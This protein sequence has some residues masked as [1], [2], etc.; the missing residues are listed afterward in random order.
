MPPRRAATKRLTREKGLGAGVQLERASLPS[1]PVESTSCSSK[2][3]SPWG[4]VLHPVQSANEIKEEHRLRACGISLDPSYGCPNNY[5]KKQEEDFV[6]VN[7][8]R[9]RQ[10]VENDADSSE[11][12]VIIVSSDDEPNPN[13]LTKCACSKK[14]CKTNPRCLNY[15]GQILW[16]DESA[17]IRPVY[18]RTHSTVSLEKSKASFFSNFMLASS[19][20]DP[21]LMSRDPKLPVGLKVR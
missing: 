16:E 7:G 15:L 4:W 20:K 8:P 5:V 21:A 17:L 9:K 2:P 12:D 1:K 11:A 3:E 10:K 6:K 19:Q 13:H 18:L 14:A